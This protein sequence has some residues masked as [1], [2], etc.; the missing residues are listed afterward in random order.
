MGKVSNPHWRPLD[1]LLRNAAGSERLRH[2]DLMECPMRA[3]LLCLS[4]LLPL[5]ALAQDT[6]TE[7][8]VGDALPVGVY[9]N[10]S[11]SLN[12]PLTG[13]D[14]ESKMAEEDAYRQSLY[15]RAVKE[16]A[17]LMEAIAKSCTITA[18]NV[19]TQVNANPGQPDYLYA[20][21]SITMTVELK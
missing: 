15:A 4:A 12:V 10:S 11:I 18:V 16:C 19:S 1:A 13:T 17:G 3:L 7:V 14:L 20:T 9:F 8:A 5:P 2:L 21:A 6:A